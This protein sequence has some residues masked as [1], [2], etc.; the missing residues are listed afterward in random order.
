[1][2][3]LLK[4]IKVKIPKKVTYTSGSKV[5]SAEV[6]GN[7]RDHKHLFTIYR[8]LNIFRFNYEGVCRLDVVLF[9]LK[10]K[11][12]RDHICSAWFKSHLLK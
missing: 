10:K 4:L 3:L 2:C 11:V 8:Q 5:P 6:A 7:G 1:M 12:L 9:M